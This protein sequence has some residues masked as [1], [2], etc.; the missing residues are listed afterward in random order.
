MYVLQAEEIEEPGLR[1]WLVFNGDA[2]LY[3]G[4]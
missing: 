3:E 4:W 2:Y 1:I